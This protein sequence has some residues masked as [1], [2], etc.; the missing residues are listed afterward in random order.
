[1]QKASAEHTIQIRYITFTY[2]YVHILLK[3]T[4]SSGAIL[5]RMASK[6]NGAFLRVTIDEDSLLMQALQIY[7][8]PTFDPSRQ[9]NVTFDKQPAV[10][11]GGPKREFYTQLLYGIATS[12]GSILPVMFEGEEGRPMPSYNLSV[13]YSGM[14][15]VVGKIIALSIVQ[16][17]VGFPYLSPVC[18]WYLITGD[19]SKAIS[20]GKTT[21]VRDRVCRA[22]P[23][24]EQMI[25]SNF[26]IE[27][28]SG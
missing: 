2:S 19:V 8:N 13:V 3:G 25:Q 21:D 15:K 12:D 14:M 26:I 9:L 10:D 18:Y 11:T 22:D 5:D 4:S 24:G 7:K 16:C 28:N 1:M 27:Y 17:G 20:Y 23:Q 6:L